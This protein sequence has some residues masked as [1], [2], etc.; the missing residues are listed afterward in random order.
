MRE[1]KKERERERGRDRERIDVH[2]MRR[3]YEE[4]GERREIETMI[5]DK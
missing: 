2:G 5:E 4:W 1:R 3:F